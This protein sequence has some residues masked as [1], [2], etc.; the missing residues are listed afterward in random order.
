MSRGSSI[1][2]WQSFNYWFPKLTGYWYNEKL[3]RLHFWLM[4]L[5]FF[6][7]TIPWYRVRLLGMPRQ[8]A[9]YGPALANSWRSRSLEWQIP[10]PPPEEDCPVPPVVSAL[11][12]TA[13]RLCV[14]PLRQ[15]REAEGQELSPPGPRSSNRSYPSQNLLLHR[16]LLPKL[17]TPR[18]P[19]VDRLLS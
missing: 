4:T 8:V 6:I 10:S 1:P 17:T 13:A 12:T 5:G 14:C 9:D 18:L 19:T 7:I 16:S 3:G 11:M 2:F 15:V